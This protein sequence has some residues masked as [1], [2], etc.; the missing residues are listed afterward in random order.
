MYLRSEL[1]K[2]YTNKLM[3]MLLGILLVAFTGCSFNRYRYYLKY[4]MTRPIGG[5]NPYECWMLADST[6]WGF[7]L[8]HTLFW[9]FPIAFPGITYILE[10]Q[11]SM[12]AFF[13]VRSDR[14]KYY[15]AKIIVAAIVPFVVFSVLLMANA[16]MTWLIYQ[17]DALLELDYMIP[18]KGSFAAGLFSIH[19]FCLVAFYII[20]IAF[21][22]SILSLLTLGIWAVFR[23][24]NKYVAVLSPVVIYGI[25][26]RLL[27]SVV[28]DQFSV[29]ILIQPLVSAFYDPPI[30]FGNFLC[31]VIPWT[32]MAISF[33][34][35]GWFRNKD[36]M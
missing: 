27:S 4:P 1:R 9:M 15:R 22:Q 36:I 18:K 33:L 8:F 21:I 35:I 2:L 3:V 13:I 29:K 17:P 32:V 16:A 20:Y 19:P 23:F 5:T 26:E 28:S 14:K 10:K 30:V 24:P 12:S 25:I 31:A 11:S 34:I 7:F 6:N